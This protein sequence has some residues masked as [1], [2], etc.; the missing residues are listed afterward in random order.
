MIFVILVDSLPRKNTNSFYGARAVS[1]L[2]GQSVTVQY[3][4]S[5]YE[6]TCPVSGCSWTILPQKLSRPLLFTVMMT[7]PSGYTCY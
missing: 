7:L 1:N 6:L 3:E 4:E 5:F 2:S